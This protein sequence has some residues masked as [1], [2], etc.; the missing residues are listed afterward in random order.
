LPTSLSRGCIEPI[1]H[2]E[3]VPSQQAEPSIK[4]SS[5]PCDL[6]AKGSK[7]TVRQ[8]SIRDPVPT[9]VKKLRL[10]I[11]HAA[12]LDQAHRLSEGFSVF[13]LAANMG[14]S[15]EMLENFLR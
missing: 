12:I 7:V 3:T 11:G 9:G 14:T 15:V 8:A 1:L 13:Q 10:H 5:G 6:L 2:N 4:S